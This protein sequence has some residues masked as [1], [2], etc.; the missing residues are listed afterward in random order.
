M[1]SLM[2]AL[3]LGNSAPPAAPD[4]VADL[5]LYNGRI[6]TGGTPRFVEAIALRGEHVL[7][8]GSSEEMRALAGKTTRQIDLRE[9]LVT[10]GFIDNHVHF[11]GGGFQ[12]AG[13]QLRDARST[14]EFA[15]RIGE[16]AKTIPA[17]RW[18]TRGDWDHELWSPVRLPTRAMID[19]VSPINPV[20]VS[21]FDGHMALANSVALKLAGITRESADPDGGSIVRDAKGEPTGVLKDTAM[22]AVWRVMPAPSLDERTTAAKAALAEARKFGVTSLCDMSDG[23]SAFDDLRA[24]QRLQRENALTSRIYLFTPLSSLQRLI[25]AGITRGFGN[26]KL[27]IGGLKGFADGSL[28]SA[29]ALFSKPYTDDPK[30]IGLEMPSIG[31]GDVKKW[32]GNAVEHDLQVAI[33]AIGDKANANVLDIFEAQSE[34]TARRFRIEHAQHLDSDLVKRF[35]AGRV[36]ASMQPYHA[37]DDGRWAEKKIGRDRSRHTYAF[38]SLI[39][40]GAMLTFGSDWTVAP[41]DPIQ[42][43]YAAVTRRTL[44]GKNPEG[45]FKEQK[46]SVEEAL[47]CYTVNNAWAMFKEDSIGKLAPGMLADLVVLSEDL[48]KIAPEKVEGVKVEL[49]IVGGEVVFEREK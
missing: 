36:I 42:G 39:D 17:N 31:N 8:I 2:L 20:F 13:V 23:D 1:I 40:A 32:V 6:W 48:F 22:D 35:A 19:A 18:I 49:T 21:R 44:D 9:R 26:E 41:L 43:I 16:Y 3:L 7:A 11:T 5:V 47:R 37:I 27:S 24:Y 12:L 28:G 45:W 38:R 46:I 25:D 30:S 4:G 29:T 14:E 33:H 10:P 15:K 34:H